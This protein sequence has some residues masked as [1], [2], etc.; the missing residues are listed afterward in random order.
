MC[1]AAL[2]GVACAS[3]PAGTDPGGAGGEPAASA[4][5]S[6]GGKGGD[7]EAECPPADNPRGAARPVTVGL[8]SGE[9]VDDQGEPTSSGLVQICGR[10]ICVNARVGDDG[11]LAQDVAQVLDDPA[12]KFGDGLTWGKLAIPLSDGDTELGT[13]TTARL[14]DFADGVP[15]TP[16]QAIS[17]GGVTLTLTA[18]AHV[19]VDTLT[20]EDDSQRGFR[21]V[22]LPEAALSQLNQDF[23]AGF[24]LSPVDTRICPSPALSLENT[25]DLAPGAALELYVLGVD[26][27][28]AL[29]PYGDWKK[30]GEGHVSD[31]GATLEFPDGLPLLSAIGIREK[32]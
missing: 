30:V 27:S 20:Y 17:S 32:P 23:V 13:L 6:G 22:A 7:V 25:P 14:P 21:A 26:V 5:S 24:A 15:F 29:A 16:G 4:G 10:D 11:K 28:E 12:C 31:D 3:D 2:L 19:E 9:I 18:D 8:V 1:A